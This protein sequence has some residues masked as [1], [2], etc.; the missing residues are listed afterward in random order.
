LIQFISWRDRPADAVCTVNITCGIEVCFT[1]DSLELVR[2]EPE[3]DAIVTIPK[4]RLN[5]F[6]M[7]ENHTLSGHRSVCDMQLFQH[8]LHL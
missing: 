6:C 8:E 1:S 2:V 3:L 7:K 5:C 4:L